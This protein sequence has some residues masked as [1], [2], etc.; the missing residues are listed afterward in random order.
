MP[1]FAGKAAGAGDDAAV[2]DDAAADPGAEDGA[3][4]DTVAATGSLAGFGQRE[5]VCIIGDEHRAAELCHKVGREPSAIDAGDI[6]AGDAA[7]GR[8]DHA[9]DRDG[10]RCI[11]RSVGRAGDVTDGGNE[12]AERVE[13]RWHP[14]QRRER[15]RAGRQRRLDPGTANIDA[16]NH[17]C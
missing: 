16:D 9:G 2:D 1:P 13:R 3:E 10:D 14:A 6:G 12:G 7:V 15:G 17:R 5:T 11:G 4:D 8:I